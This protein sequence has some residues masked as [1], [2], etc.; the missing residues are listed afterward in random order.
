MPKAYIIK[1]SLDIL[2][3]RNFYKKLIK[4]IIFFYIIIGIWFYQII[5]YNFYLTKNDYVVVTT[6]GKLIEI[7][8]QQ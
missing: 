2:Y 1:K 6:F 3:L 5:L 7:F 4:S 8:P